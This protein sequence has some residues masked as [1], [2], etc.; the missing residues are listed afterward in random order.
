MALRTKTIEFATSTVIATLAAA[1]SRDVTLTAYI[2]ESS[3]TFKSVTL[4][5]W[6]RDNTTTSATMTSPVLGIAPTL[7]GTYS[8]VTLSNP[9]ANT[10]EGQTYFFSGM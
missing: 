1:T 2:P 3:I 10:G 9:P 8:E 7:G 5:C 4:Q 6:V